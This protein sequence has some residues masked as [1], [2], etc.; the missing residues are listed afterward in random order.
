MEDIMK[1][2][3]VARETRFAFHRCSMGYLTTGPLGSRE[4]AA[5]EH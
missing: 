1:L 3:D 4:S 5:D 2:C